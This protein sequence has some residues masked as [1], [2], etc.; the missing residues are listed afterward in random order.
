MAQ[1]KGLTT[2]Q[3]ALAPPLITTWPQKP[4]KLFSRL[5]E[6]KLPEEK[7]GK[8]ED[9]VITLNDN[10]KP[11]EQEEAQQEAEEDDY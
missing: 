11:E 7:S 3:E 5:L 9:W 8:L 6:Q 4:R 1:L 2:Q 10:L